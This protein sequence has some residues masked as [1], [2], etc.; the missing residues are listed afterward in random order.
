M[1]VTCMPDADAEADA[2]AEAEA[3]STFGTFRAQYACLPRD[4]E[5]QVLEA[6]LA[7]RADGRRALPRRCCAAAC[8]VMTAAASGAPWAAKTGT[9][10][11][12]LTVWSASGTTMLAA[13]WLRCCEPHH[14]PSQT[15][16]FVLASPP[17]LRSIACAAAA[18]CPVSAFASS[19]RPCFRLRQPPCPV[20][21][22]P[23]AP[24]SCSHRRPRA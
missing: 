10:P 8:A 19:R 7:G 11:R 12:Q 1:Q 20:L 22:P 23:G 4:K 21:V 5:E 16:P 2:E 24:V 14:D 6:A 3:R 15:P 17:P 9:M 13:E 18:L